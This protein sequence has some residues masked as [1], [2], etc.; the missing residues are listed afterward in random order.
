MCSTVLHTIGRAG[1]LHIE[2]MRGAGAPV[3]ALGGEVVEG[4]AAVAEE[5]VCF[6]HRWGRHPPGAK[7]QEGRGTAGR[8]DRH[9]PGR[10]TGGRGD[11]M[12]APIQLIASN[13]QVNRWRMAGRRRRAA[14]P[15]PGCAGGRPASPP[16]PPPARGAPCGRAT[17]G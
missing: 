1:A 4:L 9:P 12:D 17:S 2:A 7:L 3:A 16:P 15:A 14:R 5:G 11:G 10:P 13:A 8:R 6:L